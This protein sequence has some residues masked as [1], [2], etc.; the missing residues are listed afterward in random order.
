MFRHV[1]PRPFVSCPFL[2]RRL[3]IT[4]G[5]MDAK[6]GLEGYHQNQSK[7]LR[8]GC[9]PK[10]VPNCGQDALQ[11]KESDRFKSSLRRTIGQPNPRLLQARRK[12][13]TPSMKYRRIR[14]YNCQS[15]AKCLTVVI[16]T[17]NSSL[18][19]NVVG[20]TRARGFVP[21]CSRSV[22]DGQ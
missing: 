10:R 17:S 3:G 12:T 22:R 21:R 6:R 11:Q 4:R 14:G 15:T 5:I 1:D 8:M 16:A 20:V 9:C 18:T 19:D 7:V 13:L 2:T